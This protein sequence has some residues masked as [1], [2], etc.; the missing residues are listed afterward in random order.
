VGPYN[1]AVDTTNRFR[2][3]TVAQFVD[4]LASGEPVPGGGAAAAVAGSL[5][6]ALVAMVA[7]LSAGRPKYAEHAALLDRTIPV[8]RELQ[9]RMLALADEDAE[10][11]AGYGAAMK[12]PRET[13]EE[14]AIRS[15]AIRKAALAATLSPLR[16]VEATLEIVTLAEGLAGRS[17]RNASSDLEVAALMS[18]AAC[19]A[20]A[21][22]VYINLPSLGDETK[23]R[24][25]YE[26]TEGIADAVER[27]A[28]QTREHVRQGEARDPLPETSA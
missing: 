7:N 17:N 12:L 4:A 28:A 15:A 11:F 26:R 5:G 23:A 14:K 8:A 25:L 10:A 24:D 21:A 18:V 2:D 9:D 16:T 22:N 20:A 19:R 1:R 27:L 6:A 3:L 13:D